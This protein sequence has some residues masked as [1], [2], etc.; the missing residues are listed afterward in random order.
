MAKRVTVSE[1]KAYRIEGVEIGGDNY[2]SVRQ[3]YNTKK[4]PTWKPGRQGVTIPVD[5]AAKIGKLLAE[6]AAGDEF[7]VIEPKG[8]AED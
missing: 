6:I 1:H 3:L 8:K 2:V 5:K 4:D 7:K